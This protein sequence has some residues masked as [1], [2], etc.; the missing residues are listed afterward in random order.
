M[1]ND[2]QFLNVA[3][4]IAPRYRS[5]TSSAVRNFGSVIFGLSTYR[6]DKG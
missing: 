2:L 1:R 4:E 6:S 3:T 5:K